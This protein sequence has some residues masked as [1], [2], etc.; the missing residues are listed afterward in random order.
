MSN[1]YRPPNQKPLQTISAPSGIPG[2]LYPK[3]PMKLYNSLGEFRDDQNF[4]TGDAIIVSEEKIA[5]ELRGIGFPECTCLSV[6]GCPYTIARNLYATLIELDA[7]KTNR[8][9]LIFS[10]ENKGASRAIL[11][12]LQ[13]A[14]LA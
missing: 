9:H 7:H 10:G 6:D 1:C 4:G 3:T 14:A 11:D 12:R 13:R 8:M 5:L 2:T